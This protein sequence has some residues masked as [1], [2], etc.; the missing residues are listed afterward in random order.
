MVA[1][2]TGCSMIYS[3]STPSTPFVN[4]KDGN[5]VA[6]GNS[7]FEDNAE[8][9]YGMALAQ[10]FKE[11]RIL[12]VMEDNMD[13]VEP[14]LKELF[15]KYI[16][17]GSD[18]DAQRELVKPIIDAVKASANE[19]VKELVEY[20]R[21][22]VGKSVWIVGGDGWAYDI[23]YGGLDHVLANN[24]N[25]NVLVLDTEVYS[26]TGGQSSKSS[27]AASIAKF[28]AGGKPTAKKDLGQIAMAYGHVY[29]ASI[30]M[31]AN[32]AQTL[33]AIK[34]AESY[35]GPSLIIA[36]SPCANHGIKGGLANHQLVQKAAVECGYVT[37]YRFDP[38]KEQPLTIDS[39]APDFDKFNEF[40]LNE[41]RYTQ[42]VKLKGDK[43]AYE[44]FEIT[45]KDAEKRYNRLVKLAQD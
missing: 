7:L 6:W 23:G 10:N 3:S 1:N 19:A 15:A 43:T 25:V 28:T 18:R 20:E 29:V 13:A 44:M 36:Y 9:G 21:D 38:R 12:K 5:G 4:D 35:D 27:Q 40:L 42:L 26:N 31:G 8:Y 41:T 37:L 16:E 2:A 22:L 34:E 32:K 24:L 30:S 33:K 17:V 11:A 45:R 39:K 14:E